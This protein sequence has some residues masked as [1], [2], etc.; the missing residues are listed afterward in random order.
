[1]SDRREQY[2]AGPEE[3]LGKEE[4]VGVVRKQLKL[5]GE[6]ACSKTWKMA[7]LR[8]SEKIKSMSEFLCNIIVLLAQSQG[9]KRGSLNE[10]R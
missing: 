5:G 9:T 2:A 4:F 10:R 3:T 8:P 1:M 7:L 6:D